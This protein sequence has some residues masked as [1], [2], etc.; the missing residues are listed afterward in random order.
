LSEIINRGRN[1]DLTDQKQPHTNNLDILLAF[2]LVSMASMT[3]PLPIVAGPSNNN[4]SSNASTATSLQIAYAQPS[5]DNNTITAHLREPFQLRINQTAIIMPANMSIRFLDALED[6]RCPTSVVCAW[7]GQVTISLNVTE[8]S[9]SFPSM[10]NLTLGPSSSNSSASVGSHIVELLEVEPYP[11][12]DGIIPK[13]DYI[14]NLMTL[15][16]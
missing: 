3:I 8:L 2:F 7:A 5:Q 13:G 14:A 10:L 15:L 1:N 12:G 16:S 6:S 11:M 9:P 4:S